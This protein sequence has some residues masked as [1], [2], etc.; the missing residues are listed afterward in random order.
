M[1]EEPPFLV[2]DDDS[3]PEGSGPQGEESRT[4][5]KTRRGRACPTLF[6]WGR[7]AVPLQ[8]G[9][10]REPFSWF[11][12]ARQP[13]G[14]SDCLENT[15]SEIPLRRSPA[16]AIRQWPDLVTGGMTD[17]NDSLCR[18]VTQTPEGREALTTIAVGARRRLAPTSW[19]RKKV[20]DAFFPLFPSPFPR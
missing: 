10:G 9:K 6:T 13:T 17:R 4:A 1:T 5:L 14:M 7:Q 20:P 19:P 8:A 3:S 18:V 11:L 2:A 12:G 15:Q 16:P